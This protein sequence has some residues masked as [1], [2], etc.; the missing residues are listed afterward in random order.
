MSD[1]DSRRGL[2]A[3]A[4][5]FTEAEIEREVERVAS[6]TDRDLDD[7][8]R[9]QGLDPDQPFDLEKMLPEPPAKTAPVAALRP[10]PQWNLWLVAASFAAMAVASVVALRSTP[11][12]PDVAGGEGPQ[13]TASPSALA[14]AETLRGE[15]ERACA[16][17][18][19]GAC[20]QRLDHAKA[21]DPEG[22]RQERVRRWRAAIAEHRFNSKAGPD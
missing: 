10:R 7:A 17:Q 5:L 2:R 21:L 13:P 1:P 9:S 14:R 8:L 19:W 6:M 20:A 18:L 12:D 3:T 11:T 16:Q 22:E 4:D 15:A